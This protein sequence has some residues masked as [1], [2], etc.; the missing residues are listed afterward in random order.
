MA[1][2]NSSGC[3]ATLRVMVGC[4]PGVSK[5]LPPFGHATPATSTK[6]TDGPSPGQEPE[7]ESLLLNAAPIGQQA[8]DR[9]G[10]DQKLGDA[11]VLVGGVR[12]VHGPCTVHHA[13]HVAEAD[14]EAHIRAVGDAFY[15]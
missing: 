7:R 6:C 11:Y 14:K 2:A 4:E 12:H 13:R 3:S 8:G 9:G 5:V 1:R 10:R 15:G